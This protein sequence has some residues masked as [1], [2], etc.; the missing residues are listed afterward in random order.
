MSAATKETNQV[1]LVARTQKSV[2][3]TLDRA[4]ELT[5]LSATQI[6]TEAT[7]QRAREL[8]DR[9]T[10]IDVSPQGAEE[11]LMALDHPP[12]PTRLLERAR[13]RRGVI[14]NHESGAAR[15]NNP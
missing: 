8:I 5:G 12:E 4:C 14:T 10:R 3:D 9:V 13:Q 15:Q 11:M 2:K 6:I 7:E 1:R